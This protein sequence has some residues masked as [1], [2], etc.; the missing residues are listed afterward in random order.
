[1]QTLVEIYVLVGEYETALEEIEGLLSIPSGLSPAGMA[2][3]PLFAPLHDHP[4]YADR[5][6]AAPDAS[7]GAG[8]R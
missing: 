6:G 5:T 8:G 3:D 1:M 2:V 4:G 7:E